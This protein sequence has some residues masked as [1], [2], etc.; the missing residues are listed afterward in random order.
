MKANEYQ[1]HR[2]IGSG[3]I[4]HVYEA[5]SGG[6]RVAIKMLRAELRHSPD[7]IALLEREAV[8]A[9]QHDYAHLI[10]VHAL[11]YT[12]DGVP[13]LVMERLSGILLADTIACA[14]TDALLRAVLG[15]ALDGLEALHVQSIV[16]CDV[17]P[18]NLMLTEDGIV[19]LL[20][21]GVARRMDDRMGRIGGSP[22]Y[23]APELLLERWNG[24]VEPMADLYSLAATIYHCIAGMPPYGL[25]D[26][27]DIRTRMYSVDGPAAFA[28][29]IADDVARVL[30]GQLAVRSQERLFQSAHDM[31]DALRLD[32]MACPEELAAF[33]QAITSAKAHLI[34]LPAK[35]VIPIRP[36]HPDHDPIGTRPFPA[37]S[38]RFPGKRPHLPP[39]L[40]RRRRVFLMLGAIALICLWAVTVFLSPH[41]IERPVVR[42]AQ[43][44]APTDRSV[45]KPPDMAM[46]RLDKQNRVQPPDDEKSAHARATKKSTRQK[47]NRHE[48]DSAA[49]FRVPRQ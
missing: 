23:M 44:N 41:T 22:P 37:M 32:A 17:S 25:G 8:M 2:W 26:I 5:S 19:K 21:Y 11:E 4:A 42:D 47:R 7:Y 28:T 36:S 38:R 40:Q 33:V 45:A 30:F 16:H 18:S 48:D 20:D 43:Q 6:Q 34:G 49:P 31:R 46:P 39:Q 29:P 24:V 35:P 1:I 15:S 10:R 9:V 13:F 12:P 3:G 27:D 14:W